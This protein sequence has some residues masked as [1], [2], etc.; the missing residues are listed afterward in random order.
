MR[1]DMRI[2]KLRGMAKGLMHDLKGLGADVDYTAGFGK[3]SMQPFPGTPNTDAANKKPKPT[4]T[5]GRTQSIINAGI[6]VPNS[7]LLKI[8]V[9]G[10]P[11]IQWTPL[12]PFTVDDIPEVATLRT[13]IKDQQNKVASDFALV[14]FQIDNMMSTKFKSVPTDVLH[15]ID[16]IHAIIDNFN[17]ANKIFGN[18]QSAMKASATTT[19][20]SVTAAVTIVSSL[21]DLFQKMPLRIKAISDSIAATINKN[22]DTLVKDIGTASAATAYVI[23]QKLGVGVANYIGDLQKNIQTFFT[24]LWKALA[25]DLSDMNLNISS[26]MNDMTTAIGKDFNNIGS[27][28]GMNMDN[29]NN[30]ITHNSQQMGKNITAD[31]ANK[32]AAFQTAIN[33]VKTDVLKTMDDKVAFVQTQMTQSLTT[34]KADMQKLTDDTKASVN[35][36]LA[37]TKAQLDK[38]VSDMTATINNIKSQI[39]ATAA[40]VQAQTSAINDVKSK[41]DAT[42]STVSDQAKRVDDATAQVLKI[43]DQLQ[44]L[45]DK[46]NE[47]TG[48]QAATEAKVNKPFS[49]FGL[50]GNSENDFALSL[51]KAAYVL[52][53]NKLNKRENHEATS[54]GHLINS[55]DLIIN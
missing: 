38:S 55:S 42:A 33:Q 19:K 5:F 31:I 28:M 17:A 44:V 45:S 23:N 35:A 51:N 14:S 39:D 34:A 1:G 2:Y 30:M 53:K 3:F 48:K 13:V 54:L 21:N 50:R 40:N 16:S 43:Q 20:D 15:I 4:V 29:L 46:V 26:Y 18:A 7:N 36:S 11:T 49:F 10:L 27:W 32:I 24:N 9:S 47:L 25:A 12:Q 52:L 8:D 37:A 22:A 41:I 6:P